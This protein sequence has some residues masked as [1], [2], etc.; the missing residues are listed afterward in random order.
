MPKN[1]FGDE[2][3][4]EIDRAA[5]EWVAR[6][7]RDPSDPRITQELQQWLGMSSR[8]RGAFAHARASLAYLDANVALIA[9][10]NDAL[11][12]LPVERN[13]LL[14]RRR[15]LWL[16]GGMAAAAAAA[17]I[18]VLVR[19]TASQTYTAQR[20]EILNVPLTD[21]TMVALDTA[22]KIEVRYLA[23]SR[24]IE[25]VEGRASFD[26]AKD[27]TRPFTVT[28]GGLKVRAVGTSFVVSNT[29][30][31]SPEVMVRQGTVDVGSRLELDPVRVGANTRVVGQVLNVM[32]VD[33]AEV[34]RELAWQQGYFELK[35]AT[36]AWVAKE[37]SRYSDT[38]IVI[39]DPKIAA[40]TI[41]GRFLTN[42][43]IGFARAAASSFGLKLDMQGQ[44]IRLL[45][46]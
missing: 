37:Y 40:L 36:L 8:H 39:S 11:P 10:R 6:I 13:S 35:E 45:S 14:S 30:V 9:G 15:V 12:P 25:L 17:A 41:T 33:P 4:D 31:Q 27:K 20:G 1:E 26:V 19:G 46:S 42:N 29:D 2:V 16:G 3:G 38:R 32:P 18:G 44:E 28:A 24:E 22:S 5:A 23:Q 21:G 7:D 34:S 43:P